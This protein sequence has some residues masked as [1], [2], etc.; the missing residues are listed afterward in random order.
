MLMIF[1]ESKRSENLD[2]EDAAAPETEE[3]REYVETDETEEL[4]KRHA[5]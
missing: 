3:K 2:E 5:E 4:E 1:P